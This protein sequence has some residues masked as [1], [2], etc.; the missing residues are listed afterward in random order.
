MAVPRPPGSPTRARRP[1]LASLDLHH[2]NIAILGIFLVPMAV[3]LYFRDTPLAFFE[4]YPHVFMLMVA[5]AA[6][7][8][9][10]DDHL[11]QMMMFLVRHRGASSSFGRMIA[12]GP[13]HF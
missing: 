13:D 7:L 1:L 5:M 12:K 2:F 3:S 6:Q 10:L 4:P 9:I 8:V 11:V